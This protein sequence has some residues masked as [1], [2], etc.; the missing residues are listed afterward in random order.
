MVFRL[1]HYVERSNVGAEPLDREIVP[2]EG[3]G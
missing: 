2:V 3:W 1:N